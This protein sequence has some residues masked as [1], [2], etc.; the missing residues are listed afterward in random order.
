MHLYELTAKKRRDVYIKYFKTVVWL[1]L[2]SVIYAY[3]YT[4]CIIPANAVTA[5]KITD[6]QIVLP[7]IA[8][9]HKSITD[10]HTIINNQQT[11]LIILQ[12][13][14]REKQKAIDTYAR[15][16]NTIFYK[17]VFIIFAMCI[18]QLCVT[19]IFKLIKLY[20]IQKNKKKH[21]Y[22]HAD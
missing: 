3:T 14:I 21:N 1:S 22:L 12:Q 13:Y 7:F 4:M 17:C 11:Q 15:I 9:E 20:T 10:L 8:I 6:K 19:I 2:A 16:Q 18:S 5:Y